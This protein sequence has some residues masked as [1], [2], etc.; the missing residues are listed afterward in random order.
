MTPV[1]PIRCWSIDFARWASPSRPS[2]CP[3]DPLSSACFGGDG[4]R[5]SGGAGRGSGRPGTRPPWSR[6]LNPPRLTPGTLAWLLIGFAGLVFFAIAMIGG[7]VGDLPII[8][9]V[10]LV[11]WLLYAL[12]Y[13]YLQR[14]VIL[15]AQGIRI[16][17]WWRRWMER[18]AADAKWTWISWADRPALTIG[19]EAMRPPRCGDGSPGSASDQPARGIWNY[20]HGFGHDVPVHFSASAASLDDERRAVVYGIGKRS[21]RAGRAAERRGSADRGAHAV[22]RSTH[23]TPTSGSLSRFTRPIILPHELDRTPR[24]RETF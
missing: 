8:A 22:K 4:E 3:S 13:P 11:L 2:G 24:T 19:I 9:A 18:D 23:E 16:R 15:D 20:R 21:L 7:P 5:I 14:E 1:S 6:E 10:A 12:V 17:P